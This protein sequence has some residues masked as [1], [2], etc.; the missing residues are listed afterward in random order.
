MHVAMVKARCWPI[1]P[2][3]ANIWL[4]NMMAK[5]VSLHSQMLSIT[6]EQHVVPGLLASLMDPVNITLCYAA[7]PD[8]VNGCA[9]T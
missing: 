7:I 2:G 3:P 6:C 8:D 9:V 1:F 5:L 4:C